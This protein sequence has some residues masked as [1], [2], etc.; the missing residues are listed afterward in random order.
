MMRRGGGPTRHGLARS[1]VS[2]RI[3]SFLCEGWLSLVA[4]AGGALKL[5]LQHQPDSVLVV[6]DLGNAAANIIEPGQDQ[7]ANDEG[8]RR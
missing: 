8:D 6:P 7:D 2:D 1:G 4:V 3:L 5:L